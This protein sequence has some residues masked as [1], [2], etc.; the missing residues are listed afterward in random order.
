VTVRRAGFRRSVGGG[1]P[2][3]PAVRVNTYGII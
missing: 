3:M 1:E 2:V